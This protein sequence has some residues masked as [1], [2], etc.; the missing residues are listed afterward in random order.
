MLIHHHM[1][2]KGVYVQT[3]LLTSNSEIVADPGE[4]EQAL[5]AL[6]VNAIEAMPTGG[7]L[8]VRLRGTRN[9]VMIDIADTG[10]GIPAD[11]LPLI[12]EP[13]F[14]TKKNESGS[15]LGLA[16]VYG[17]VHRHGGDIDVDSTVGAGTTFHI[18]LPRQPVTAEVRV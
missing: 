15:G 7:Q 18:R 17:I 8:R 10:P 9:D 5:V 3:E 1:E 16:V 11:I 2:M 4:L 6:L 14:T 12:F 13:F